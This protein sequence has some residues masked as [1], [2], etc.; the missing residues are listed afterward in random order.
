M[1]LDRVTILVKKAAL[2]AEKT[3]LPILQTYDLTV[4]QYKILKYLFDASKDSVRI[5][6]L[7]TVFSITHPA[8]I[9][10]LKVLEKKGY[11]TRIV[12]PDDARSK[13]VSLTEKAYAE[14]TLLR[15]LGDEM[16]DAV[17]KRL[18]EKEKE[19]LIQLL[20]KLVGI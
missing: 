20:K 14:E 8:A 18:S 1:Y 13:I 15:G 6:D 3:Q 12:N 2:E 16:E 17:T 11:T 5:I 10:I 9:D 4:A 19:Q 7:E